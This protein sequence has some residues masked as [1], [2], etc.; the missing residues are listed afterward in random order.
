RSNLI[1][2][3]KKLNLTGFSTPGQPAVIVVEGES[4]ACEEY[5]KEVK[6]WTW[7]RISLRHSDVLK[8]SADMKFTEF[9]EIFHSGGGN[10][11]ADV[12]QLLV[13]A[14]LG[15]RFHMLY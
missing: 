2:F 7:K 14:N 11:M 13:D 9:R 3:A 1:H 12:K 10:A 5:W 8:S 6:S 15:D 4:K